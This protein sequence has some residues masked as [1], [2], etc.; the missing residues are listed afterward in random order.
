MDNIFENAEFGDK[1]VRRDGKM[2]VFINSDYYD[3]V[4][5][6]VV[7]KVAQDDDMYHCYA[8]G[9]ANKQIIDNPKDIVSKWTKQIS[10]KEL[11]E[12]ANKALVHATSLHWKDAYKQGFVDAI[13]KL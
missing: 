6:E 3:R 5:K 9:L 4:E 10:A 1:F 11:E 13:S 2:V 8:N 12:L 7:Y